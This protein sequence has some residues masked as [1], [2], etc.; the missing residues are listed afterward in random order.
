MRLAI[1][2]AIYM[3]IVIVAMVILGSVTKN[4]QLKKS[5]RDMIT[6]I[7]LFAFFVMAMFPLIGAVVHDGP[8]CWFFQKWGNIFMGLFMFF[9]M[10]LAAVA[11]IELIIWTV[12]RASKKKGGVPHGAAAM[13]IIPLIVTVA[14]NLAGSQTAHDV[15]VTNYSIEKEKLG[16][17]E[18]ARIVLFADTHIGVNSTPKIYE[19]MVDRINEQDADLV[20]VA[21]DLV[22]SSFGAMRDPETYASIM[23]GIESK[24]GVYAVYGNHDVDEPLL[25]GFTYAGKESAKRNPAMEGWVSDCGWKLLTDDV[26]RIPELNGLVIAGRRDES[27]PGEGFDERAPLSDLLKETDPDDSILLLQHEPSDL[28][29]LDE[30]GVDLS[31]SG[32]THDGQIFPGNIITKIL[33]EQSYGMENWGDAIAVVTSGVGY[34]GPPIRVC[35]ISEI[36]VI[37]L[38]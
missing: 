36:V 8:V 3:A 28:Y 33:T 23:R 27:R 26:M 6:F 17:T 7:S 35:T 10:T 20:V 31:V 1:M 21:G 4:I 9:F 34:Y 29:E 15:K 18:P 30:Y 14:V 12:R 2:I 5:S 37:D 38:I 22:T 24:Y 32:H 19:D 13:L 16:L 25:G 11:I